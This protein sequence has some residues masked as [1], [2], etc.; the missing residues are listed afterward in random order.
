MKP[1]KRSPQ[2]NRTANVACFSSHPC[3]AGCGL[4][5]RGGRT[6]IIICI[7]SFGP[8]SVLQVAAFNAAAAALYLFMIYFMLSFVPICLAGCGL[9][10]R[11]GRTI[12]ARP[13][14]KPKAFFLAT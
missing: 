12:R 10:Q 13:V 4:Q 2:L 8:I 7:Q 1:P 5:R 3:L 9:Q 11:G 6:F 14:C